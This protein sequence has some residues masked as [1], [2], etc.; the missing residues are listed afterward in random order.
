MTRCGDRQAKRALEQLFRG[1]L[2]TEGFTRLRAH[3]A[4]CAECREAYDKLARV[5]STLEKRALPVGR[6]ALLEQAL[7][8]RLEGAR[9]AA[10]PA[11]LA[12]FLSPVFLQ[13]G[14][15]AVAAVVLAVVLVPR[16]T[17][18]PT[19][20]EFVARGGEEAGSQ[21]WG[22]RAFCVD[23][24]GQ[25]RGEA[26]PDETLACAEGSSVQLSYTAPEGARLQVVGTSPSGEPLQFFPQEGGAAEVKPGVDV[27]LPYSTPVQGG[28]LSKPVKVE[29]R[30]TDAQGRPL[31]RSQLKLTPQ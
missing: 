30:F 5:E 13:A 24:A 10:R 21:A 18:P 4:G 22:L 6:E 26:R 2:D 20:P 8:A 1:E 23:A 31:A 12:R 29:A 15:G 16:L 14:L 3:A 25:L 17:A 28:W 19:E 27:L 7:F 11:G 9:Q